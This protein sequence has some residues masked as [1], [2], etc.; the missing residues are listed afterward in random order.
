MDTNLSIENALG[1]RWGI[2][3]RQLI[4]RLCCKY[5]FIRI[6]GYRAMNINKECEHCGKITTLKVAAVPVAESL[7]KFFDLILLQNICS[8]GLVKVCKKK[9]YVEWVA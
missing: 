9:L 1:W 4:R 6:V 3:I 5:K 8:L 2:T 7:L